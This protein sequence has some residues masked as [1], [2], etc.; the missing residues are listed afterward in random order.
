MNEPPVVFIVDDD[1]SVRD[2][3]KNLFRSVGLDVEAFATAQDFL[4]FQPSDAPRCLVLDVRLPGFSGLDLQR[5]LDE[6]HRDIPIVFITAHG[7]I[8]MSVQ[9]MK[10]GAVEFLTKPFRDQELLD[11]VQD[12]LERDRAVRLQRAESADLLQRYQSLSAREKEVMTL[13]VRGL[14]NKQVA[15]DLGTS[16]ATIKLH[17]GRL[18]RK[19]RAGSISDLTRMAEKI[20]IPSHAEGVASQAS[21]SNPK[22]E[23]S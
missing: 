3:M 20:G 23:I 21:P 5:K 17:R 13:V 19:M 16:E 9:A 22:L 18:M 6:T 8:R 7:D 12:A 10:A 1:I 15:A 2:S 11:A 14:L 4:A